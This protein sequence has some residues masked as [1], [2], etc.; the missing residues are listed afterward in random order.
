MVVLGGR[1]FSDERGTPVVIQLTIG[2]GATR[3]T[4]EGFIARFGGYLARLHEGLHGLDAHGVHLDLLLCR[5]H[6]RDP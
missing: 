4:G 3:W 5:E 6:P 2:R 1:A